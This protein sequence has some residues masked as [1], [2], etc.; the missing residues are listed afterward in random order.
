MHLNINGLL[1]KID[2]LRH[3]ARSSSATVIGITETKL[4]N[5]VYKFEVTVDGFNIV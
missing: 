4:D 2:E 5:T 3:I 1:N